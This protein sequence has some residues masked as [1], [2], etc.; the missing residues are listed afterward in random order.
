M[1]E[2]A[3][4]S[5][6]LKTSLTS[7]RVGTALCSM[8]ASICVT[9]MKGRFAS[10]QAA[11]I[12]FCTRGS[13]HS[14]MA[15]PRSPRAITISSHPP[16]SSG[17]LRTPSRFSILAKRRISGAPASSRAA[18]TASRSALSRTKGCMT[19]VTPQALARRMF[20]RSVSVMVGGRSVRPGRAM[21]LR[22]CRTPP[23]RT[24]AEARSSPAETISSRSFPSSSRTSWPGTRAGKISAGTGTPPAPSVTTA[25]SSSVSGASSAP[26]RSSGP[27]MS[28][29][30]C[31]VLP[32]SAA[33]AWRSAICFSAWRSVTCERLSRT[34]LIPAANIAASVSRSEQRGPS[35]P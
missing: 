2:D 33:A 10:R 7:A 13:F 34:P 14:G 21:L 27:C 25:P 30:S 5:T 17:R 28:I 4:S 24:R 6:A 32:A 1:T 12:S 19:A 23:R 16:R 3:P 15:L 26:T 31:A 20:A 9:T 35:V 29:S 22:L 18:R 11:A 8:L